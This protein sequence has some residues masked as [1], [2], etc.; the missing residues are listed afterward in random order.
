[1]SGDRGQERKVDDDDDSLQINPIPSA[2][3]TRTRGGAGGG[4]GFV[5]GVLERRPPSRLH[6]RL[7]GAVI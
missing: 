6:L 5:Q 1:M 2:R 3:R 7:N 4:L